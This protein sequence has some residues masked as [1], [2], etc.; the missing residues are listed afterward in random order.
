MLYAYSIFDQ[1][2]NNQHT[3]ICGKKILQIRLYACLPHYLLRRLERL[4]NACIRFI[5]NI[6]IFN[7]NL[8]S[9]YFNSHILPIKYRINYKLCLTV[10]KILNNLSPKY[11]TN[12]VIAYK[13]LKENLR[14][15]KDN[16]IINTTHH[17]SKTI[18]HQMC[19]IWN[20]LPKSLRSCNQ[21][22]VFKKELKTYFL[23]KLSETLNRLIKIS[24]ASTLLR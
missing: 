6:S 11:L 4:L 23:R 9:Y 20:F 14:S 2:I 7:H 18:S 16:W 1:S 24:L 15:G 13:P 12:L 21:T 3:F 17:I 8:L 19:L 10:H 5:F 22:N